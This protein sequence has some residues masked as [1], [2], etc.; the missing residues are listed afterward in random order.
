MN[1]DDDRQNYLKELKEVGINRLSIGV[2]SFFDDELKLMNRAHSADE[3]FLLL[4]KVISQ[5]NE[6]GLDLLLKIIKICSLHD[7]YIL[8]FYSIFRIFHPTML[9]QCYTAIRYCR[10]LTITSGLLLAF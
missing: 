2:Q 9:I 10:V 8:Y 7:N 1:P 5:K 6:P 3:A 4:K